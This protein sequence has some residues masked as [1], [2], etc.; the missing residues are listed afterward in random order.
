MVKSVVT[1][2][3]RIN[4]ANTGT[5]YHFRNVQKIISTRT[6]ISLSNV[7]DYLKGSFAKAV[8]HLPKSCVFV[9][10]HSKEYQPDRCWVILKSFVVVVVHISFIVRSGK[11]Q[12]AAGS[13]IY[14]SG[15]FLK[16]IPQ[17]LSLKIE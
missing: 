7:W 9:L 6:E 12:T 3:L 5:V 4:K 16:G 11:Y 17:V 2:L 1:L 13:F 14:N 15:M 10:V 8:V